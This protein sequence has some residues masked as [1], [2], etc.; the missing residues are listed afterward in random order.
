MVAE[1]HRQYE[2]EQFTKIED[3]IK[4]SSIASSE[5]V[6]VP[7]VSN[8]DEIA[9]I[10]ELLE[11]HSG[12]QVEPG[13]LHLI[14]EHIS[15]ELSQLKVVDWRKR[16]SSIAKIRSMIRITLRKYGYPSTNRDDVIDQ[17]IQMLIEKG[18]EG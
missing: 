10:A 6:G 7:T 9:G 13:R 14:A 2:I 5:L 15:K 1:E 17:V 8:I 18:A 12:K 11:A 16:E 4:V 3:S